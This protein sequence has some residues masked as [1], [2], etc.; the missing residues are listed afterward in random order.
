MNRYSKAAEE[1]AAFTN[2]QLKEQISSL[3]TMDDKKVQKLFPKKLDKEEFIKLMKEVEKET[4]DANK[5]T[6]IIN[7]ITTLA[8]T[9]LKTLK[10]F[11]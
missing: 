6:Y 1:A 4:S 9:V 8:P 3:N 5:S 11:V 10:Y 2:K 7:N